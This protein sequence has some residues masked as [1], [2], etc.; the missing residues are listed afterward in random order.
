M[1]TCALKLAS[2][3]LHPKKKHPLKNL[4]QKFLQRN[5]PQKLR[6]RKKH[7]LKNLLRKNL[8]QKKNKS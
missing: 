5:P 7:P 1:K 8:Q 3:N 4:L 6:H 2:T